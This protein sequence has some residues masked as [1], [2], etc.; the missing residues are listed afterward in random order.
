V[1]VGV[2]IIILYSFQDRQG[3]CQGVVVVGDVIQDVDVTVNYVVQYS[4]KIMLVGVVLGATIVVVK[5]AQIL[6]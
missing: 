2:K 3:L 1:V 6:K 4:K 5:D